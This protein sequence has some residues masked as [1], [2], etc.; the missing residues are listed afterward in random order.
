MRREIPMSATEPPETP[1][2]WIYRGTG[3]LADGP[4]LAELLPPA[5]PWRSFNGEPLPEFE[6]IPDDKGESIRRLDRKSVV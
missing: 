1:D 6:T 5:P 2:W 4:G 3:R